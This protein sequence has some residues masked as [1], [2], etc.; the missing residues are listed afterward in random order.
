[1]SFKFKQFDVSDDR[2]T[3]KVGT[4]AVL[5]GAL[6]PVDEIG[7]ILDVGTGSG[8]IA[9]ML[10]QRSNASIDAVEIDLDAAE[11]AKHNFDASK[12]S[13][14]LLAHHSSIQNYIKSCGKLYDLIVS[15]PPYFINS[16]KSDDTKRNVA[17]HADSLPF[18]E[19][20]YSVKVLLKRDGRFCI[21]LP[22]NESNIFKDIALS[23]DLFCSKKV[24]IIP[25]MDRGC[26]RIISEYQ[27]SHHNFE[28]SNLVI[29]NCDNTYTDA[30][31]QLTKDFYLNF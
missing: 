27:L 26:N 17:R 7:S 22:E 25:K 29:R 2:C 13:D 16:L 14:R 12:W 15:N 30:Y 28:S 18:W 19:L 8:L 4:D 9:L 31:I 20:A 21:I 6:A 24:D 11:E 23:Y 10:A 1:M 3:M 5:L